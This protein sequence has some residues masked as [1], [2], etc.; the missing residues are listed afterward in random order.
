MEANEAKIY[1]ELRN[2]QKELM[3]SLRNHQCSP[4]TKPIIE[5]ELKDIEETINRIENGSYGTC[6]ISGEL[7]PNDYLAMVPTIKSMEDIQGISKYF[8]K[9]IH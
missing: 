2:I 4:L 9:S 6:E 7:I 3:E 5:E 8:C 1:L